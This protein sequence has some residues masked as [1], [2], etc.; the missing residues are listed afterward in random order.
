MDRLVKIAIVGSRDFANEAQVRAFVHTLPASTVV[1]SGGARGVDS[2]AASEAR[3]LNLG[4]LEFFGKWRDDDGAYNR[5]AG[6]DRN[7]DIVAAADRVVAFCDGL[8]K[9]IVNTISIARSQNKPV[10]VIMSEPIEVEEW[11]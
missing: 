3:K 10:D 8:S 9:G 1:V 11:E 7:K 5:A 2:W 4:V 6:F